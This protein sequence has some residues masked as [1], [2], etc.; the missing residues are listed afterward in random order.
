MTDLQMLPR[1]HYLALA[2]N[3]DGTLMVGGHLAHATVAALERL[4]AAGVKLVLTTGETPK[5]LAHF[6]HLELFDRV[7]AENGAL[8]YRPATG[9][10]RLLCDPLPPRLPRALRRAGVR[11]VKTGRAVV[12]TECSQE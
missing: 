2:T 6:P 9:T 1:M 5:D 7:V 12:S 3:G 8:L 4:R 10:E 11:P